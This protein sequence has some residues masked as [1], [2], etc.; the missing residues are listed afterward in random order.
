MANASQL[1]Q[2][3]EPVS[4]AKGLPNDHYVSDEVFAQER[5]AVLFA[6]WAAIG[7]AKDLEPGEANPIDFVGLP[8]VA[9]RDR[10]GACMER[11]PSRSVRR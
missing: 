2:V 4:T 6:N 1:T 5:E 7:F 8:L 10:D 11:V 3:L 9:V